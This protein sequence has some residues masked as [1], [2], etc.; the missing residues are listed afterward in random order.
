VLGGDDVRRLWV[1]AVLLVLLTASPAAAA[2][3]SMT[4]EP[5]FQGRVKEGEWITLWV[6]LQSQGEAAAGEVV[7]RLSPPSGME[8]L[9][10]ARYAVPYSLPAGGRQRLA[11]SLPS[12]QGWPVLVGLHEGGEQVERRTVNLTWHPRY[13]LLA[14]VLSDDDAA[15]AA[16]GRL[17]SGADTI[18]VVRLAAESLPDSPTLL[19]SLDLIALARYDTGA[20]TAAQVAALEAWVARGGTLLLFGGP[21]WERTL[22]PLPG[23]LLPVDIVGVAETPLSALGELA[24]VP[25]EGTGVVSVGQLVRGSALLRADSAVPGSPAQEDAVAGDS[26][27]G[28]AVQGSPTVLGEASS[29]GRPTGAVLA[30]TAPLGSGRV[31]YLAFDPALEPVAGWTGHAALLDRLV[32]PSAGQATAV[33]M[34]WRLQQAIQ[35]IRDWGPPLV[36]LVILLLTGYLVVVGPLNYLVLRALDRREWAW[37]TVPVLSLVFLTAVYSLGAGRFQAGISHVI[38]VTELLPEAGAGV[39]TT[40][41]GVYAPGRAHLAVPLAGGGLVRPLSTGTVV[42]G[43]QM[44][45]QNGDS[46]AIELAGLTNFTMTGFSLEHPVQQSGGL[47]LVDL[48][49]SGDDLTGRVRNSLPV[50]V[51][52]VEVAAGGALAA[53]GPLGPGETSAP[54]RIRISGPSAST[55]PKVMPHP[56]SALSA[57]ADADPRKEQLRAYLWEEG[58]RRLEVSVLVLGWTD[59]PL[60]ELPVDPPGRRASGV[61]LVYAYHPLPVSVDGNLP[62][63]AVLGRPVN[64]EA[65]AFLGYGAYYATPGS[66]FFVITLPPVDPENVSEVALDLREPVRQPAVSVYVRNQRTGEWLPLSEQRTVLPEWQEFVLPGGVIELRYD[67]LTDAEF[68]APTVAME[69]VS[70]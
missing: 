39:M 19:A 6:D 7:V 8:N 32:N 64:A 38:T 36:G 3:V 35:Q 9:S 48:T 23:R 18:R 69:G 70:R 21:E 66:Y 33:R 20:L 62:A 46:A 26:A 5:A 47:E 67:L 57:D 65:V 60:A 15:A 29:P 59:E 40:H 17:Q 25:L 31:I 50:T 55:G 49:V 12:E 2:G 1:L 24:G 41:V 42:G 4:V 63:G 61:N 37:F 28:G 68:P 11:V 45:I 34:D 44:R 58:V 10:S 14:G 43:V 56:L 27:Q 30:A 54:F 51:D 22:A 53:V 13:D 52:G 16:I